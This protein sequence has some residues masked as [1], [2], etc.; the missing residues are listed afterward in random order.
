MVQTDRKR[1][2]DRERMKRKR[3]ADKAALIALRAFAESFHVTV[4]DNFYKDVALHLVSPHSLSL[5]LRNDSSKSWI[6]AD[7]EKRRV[8]AL[9]HFKEMMRE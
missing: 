3:A 7:L 4:V 6:F 5:R 2:Y 9:S 8:E 1:A